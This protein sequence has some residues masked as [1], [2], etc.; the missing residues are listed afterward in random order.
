MTVL[1][2]VTLTIAPTKEVVES[3][4]IERVMEF[5]SWNDE[6]MFQVF[7]NDGIYSL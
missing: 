2:N 5:L 7:D 6:P 3:G 1:K 4:I